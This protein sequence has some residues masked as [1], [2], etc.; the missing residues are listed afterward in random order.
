METFW[1][2]F[3]LAV[4]FMSVWG[5][6]L[7]W[8]CEAV[9]FKDAD[10]LMASFIGWVAWIVCIILSLFLEWRWLMYVGHCVAIYFAYESARRA[11]LFNNGIW[12]LSLPVGI[13]KVM[14]SF[15]YIVT[16]MEALEPGGK[17]A[18]QKQENRIFALM[19]VGLLTLLFTKLVN[20][21][22][23]MARRNQTITLQ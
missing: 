19:I 11:H 22:A 3:T 5:V 12:R 16:W 23:V 9:F 2:I 1:K 13:A 6:V 4:L 20:G 8:T 21:E 18:A 14:L 7:G 17:T 10:D 15:I